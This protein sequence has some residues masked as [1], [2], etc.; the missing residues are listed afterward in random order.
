MNIAIV[1]D[2]KEITDI[3][4]KKI[5]SSQ[6]QYYTYKSVFDME[7]TNIHF[8]LILLDIDM[9]DCDGIEYSKK[10]KN[11]N[12]IFV[13][14]QGQRVKEAFGSHVYGFIEKSD[15]QQRYKEVV[16]MAIEEILNQKSI[17]LKCENEVVTFLQN[18]IV[19]LTYL[20]NR[21]IS[22]VYENQSYTLKGYTLKDIKNQLDSH[23][24]DISRNDVVNKNMILSMIGNKL[25]LRGIKQFFI[26]SRR[27]KT[28]IES[29]IM[30]R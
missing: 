22:M 26:V 10:H 11:Q 14:S 16:N 24:I 4:L 13:T 23:F 25:Y 15:S 8:D 12:I 2:E 9:P 18:H 7:K 30:E 1:D 29:Y 19:Y 3:I 27:K 21:T 28:M 17:T 20:G 5:E 6:H